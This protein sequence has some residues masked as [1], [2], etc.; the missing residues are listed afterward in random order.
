L[1]NWVVTQ[2]RLYNKLITGKPGRV[3][4]DAVKMQRLTEIGFQFRPRGKYMT[5]DDQMQILRKF[6][7][8]HN[9]CRVPVN[10]PELGNFVKLVRRENKKKLSGEKTSLTDARKEELE[11][12]GF[13]FEAGKVPQRIVTKPL[14]WEERFNELIQWK[15]SFICY[16]C[17]VEICLFSI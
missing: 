14:S 5:W 7:D 15:V 16:D 13:V 4:L 1:G 3:C 8:E 6:R 2:R 10:H 11:G 17:V 12:L 9:H